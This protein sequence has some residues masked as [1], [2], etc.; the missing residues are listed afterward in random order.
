VNIPAHLRDLNPDLK[1]K[2]LKTLRLKVKGEK[3]P[4]YYEN[5]LCDQLAERGV[6]RPLR[7]VMFSRHGRRWRFDLAWQEQRVAVEVDGGTWSGG[8]HTRGAGFKE[9]CIKLNH[10]AR[11]GWKVL[12]FTTDMVT[13]E[14]AADFVAETLKEIGTE[15]LKW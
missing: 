8:R 14:S 11:E 10:A 5:K 2:T 4:R 13:D 15:V 6:E 3:G 1:P 7:E 12:R 9:D